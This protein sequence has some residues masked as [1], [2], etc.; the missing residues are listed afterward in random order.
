MNGQQLVYPS[1][2]ERKNANPGELP[3]VIEELGRAFNEYKNANDE[4]LKK[5]EKGAPTGDIEVKLANVDKALTELTEL[6]SSVDELARKSARQGLGG[7]GISAEEAEHKQAFGKFVRKGVD[8]GL[9]D[10][11]AKALQIGV[12]G[13]GGYAVPKELDT[14]II[15]LL[16]KGNPMR[17]VCN[18][19]TVG[20]E[21]Y[22]RLINKGGA[23]AG[24]VGETDP[25][26]PTNTPQLAPVAPFFGEL[27]ANP[28]ATQKSLDDMYFD[29]EAWLADELAIAF[30]EAE[31]AAFTVGDGI[32]KPKGFLAYATSLN[33]DNA[34]AIGTLQHVMSGAAATIPADVLIDL[35]Y[36]LKAGYRNNAAW[37]LNSLT[38]PLLRK[39]KD[40]DGNYL[41]RPGL[42]AGEPSTLLNK[43]IVEN[44]D[45]PV[46]AAGSL[47][48]AFGDFKRGY[49]IADVYGTRVLRDP[50]SNKPYVSFYTTKRMGGGVMDSNAIK[51]LK[52]GA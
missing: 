45:M 10:L 25:R 27:Y 9:G 43:P 21:T 50:Y 38:I 41:W 26:N 12:D 42:D 33:A 8:D 48:V 19:I 52:I 34:R 22:S 14:N 46:V 5:V 16:R 18:V 32:K 2:M 29:A 44:D 4:R 28:Q 24:W 15:Q 51:L 13:D 31:S 23:N 6:K 30:A 40:A 39:L 37:M 3:R 49:T 7:N 11:Q 35:V 17:D 20:N 1:N 47:A 36:S